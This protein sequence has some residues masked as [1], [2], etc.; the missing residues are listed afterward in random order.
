MATSG[1]VTIA[2]LV[3]FFAEEPKLV[4]RG[5]NAYKSGRIEQFLYDSSSG[6]VKGTVKSSLKDRCY[7]VEVS[8]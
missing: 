6:I 2:S 5:E 3:K 8:Q 7:S 4:E 1:C